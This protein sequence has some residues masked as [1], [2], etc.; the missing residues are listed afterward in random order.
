MTVDTFRL[1]ALVSNLMDGEPVFDPGVA[2]ELYSSLP[3]ERISPIQ[4]RTRTTSSGSAFEG[5][6]NAGQA[7]FGEKRTRDY[8]LGCSRG[9]YVGRWRATRD[10]RSIFIEQRFEQPD[11]PDD[12]YQLKFGR[13]EVAFFVITYRVRKV[14]IPWFG[15]EFVLGVSTPNKR[16]WKVAK[17]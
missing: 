1:N 9:T 16:I 5:L 13:R 7:S 17:E 3:D 15:G 6:T 12:M 8:S 4:L 2:R 11:E 14:R 10:G